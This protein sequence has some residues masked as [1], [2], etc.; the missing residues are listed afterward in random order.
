MTQSSGT[1]PSYSVS[2]YTDLGLGKV[3]YTMQFPDVVGTEGTTNVFLDTFLRGNRDDQ[4]RKYE[5]SI[6]QALN[7]MNNNALV[8]QR[9]ALTGANASQLLVGARS[10]QPNEIVNLLYLNILSRYPT[11]DEMSKASAAIPSATGT[12][13]DQAIQDLAWSLY[14]KVDFIFNY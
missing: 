2:G 14:N 13:K 10:R 9:L 3:S 6:L 4:P 1:Y 12:A 11:S 5:G 7:L 8:E